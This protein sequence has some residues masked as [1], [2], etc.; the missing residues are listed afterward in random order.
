MDDRGAGARQVTYRR[1]RAPM[2]VL[3]LLLLLALLSGAKCYPAGTRVVIFVQ[4]LYTAYDASGAQGTLAEVHRFD[5]LKDAF[6]AKGYAR[7]ALLDFSYAGGTV[8]SDGAWHPASYT[9]EQTDRAP[10]DSLAAIEQMLKSYR[11]AHAN[12]HF[13]LVGHSLG[14]YLSVLEGA[15]DAAR[16][17]DQ[18]LGVDVVVTL[19]APLKG[20]SADKKIIIDLLPCDKTYLAGGDLVAQKLDAKTPDVRR[21]QAEVMAE[22]GVR[23]ATLGNEFDCLFNTGYCV[24]GD[25]FIDDTETMFLDGQASVSKRYQI[26]ASP[27][28]S[29][30][31]IVA[32]PNAIIDAVAFVGAP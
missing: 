10:A 2:I 7:A 23:V 16:P 17:A 27:F 8:S 12:A 26:D 21:Y 31:V 5:R 19:D 24:A 11:K 20:V 13:T 22:A 30:D 4:G 32:D 29:H 1:L 9:C 14:G 6:A 18:K 3:P 15:R 25:A 28:L